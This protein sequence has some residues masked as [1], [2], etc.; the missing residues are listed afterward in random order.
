KKMPGH[1]GNEK[2]TVRN[3]IVVKIDE[4]RNLIMIKGAIPGHRNSVV[5]IQKT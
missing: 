1:M 4:K 5:S 2:V 3:L